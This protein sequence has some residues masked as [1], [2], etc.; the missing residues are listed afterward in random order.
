MIT[1]RFEDLVQFPKTALAGIQRFIGWP[2]D[3]DAAA[4][5]LLPRPAGAA[6]LPDMLEFELLD[7][8]GGAR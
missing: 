5:A 3:I 6:C 1:V 7:R 8:E 2:I 4:R